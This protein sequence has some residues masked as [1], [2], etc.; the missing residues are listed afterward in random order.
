MS[1]VDGFKSSDPEYAGIVESFLEEAACEEAVKLPER[2]R[3]LA[4]IAALLG[5]QGL[6]AFRIEAK[7]ALDAGVTPV[8]VKEVVYQATDYLGIGRALSFVEAVNEVLADAGASPA[9][10]PRATTTPED[11]LE[12]GNAC[13]VEIFGEG[14]REAWNACPRE[15]STVNRWLAANCFGDYYTREGLSLA[16]REMVT[17]CYLV[18]QGGC[19]P[20][21]T[22]HAAGN[23]AVGNDKDFLY[24]VVHQ[25]LPY[26]GYPRCLNGLAC[27]DAA[28][29]ALKES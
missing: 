16:D 26:V 4:V 19:D 25:V 10:E 21:V 11:R 29:K 17:L 28:A 18:A 27:I 7:E 1:I 3:R 5:C 14:M 22:A 20:Q 13:Q 24:A 15:R 8:E 2:T 23:M 6:D 12:K 9:S